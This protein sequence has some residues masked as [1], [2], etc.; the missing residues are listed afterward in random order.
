MT[1]IYERDGF[2]TADLPDGS[3]AQVVPLTFGRGRITVSYPGD[4][5]FLRQ[6][7]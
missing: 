1:P 6:T 4:Y 5:Y 3:F 7:F 2:P